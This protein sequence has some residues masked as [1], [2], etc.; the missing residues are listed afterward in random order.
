MIKQKQYNNLILTK[1][2]SDFFFRGLCREFSNSIDSEVV[3]PLATMLGSHFINLDEKELQHTLTEIVIKIRKYLGMRVIA[4]YDFGVVITLFSIATSRDDFLP[5]DNSENLKDES[6][7][8]EILSELISGFDDDKLQP[9]YKK[10]IET[11]TQEEDANLIINYIHAN[12]STIHNR[13]KILSKLGEYKSKKALHKAML[14]IVRS[15]AQQIA[16]YQEI[17][18]II[19]MTISIVIASIFSY[20]CI[21]HFGIFAPF[22]ILP[23]TLYGIKYSIYPIDKLLEKTFDLTPKIHNSTDL[24]RQI[25]LLKDQDSKIQTKH[26]TSSYKKKETLDINILD[27][28][29]SKTPQSEPN[30]ELNALNTDSRSKNHTRRNE[31]QNINTQINATKDHKLRKHLSLNTKN[32]ADKMK[33]ELIDRGALDSDW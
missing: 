30:T 4:V 1:G 29:V 6:K 22:L 7:K 31:K 25:P 33:Q 12:K 2:K 16:S 19:N 14:D 3:H 21:M 13:Y 10:F 5:E 28:L 17:R 18:N 26:K 20:V 27:D 23:A 8:E 32:K 9:Q 15:N 11:L 24:A